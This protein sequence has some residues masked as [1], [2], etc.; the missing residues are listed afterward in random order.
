MTREKFPEKIP[1]RL[2]RML[3]NAMEVSGSGNKGFGVGPIRSA[4]ALHRLAC[5]VSAVPPNAW[6][7]SLV[8]SW[9]FHCVRNDRPWR[10]SPS[11]TS[12]LV[13]YVSQA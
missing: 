6:V 8:V 1:F 10:V 4:P 9:Y 5:R 3:T 11:F 7:S 13:S 2:T 12:D